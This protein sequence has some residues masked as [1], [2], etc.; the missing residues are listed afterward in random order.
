MYK[1]I[2]TKTSSQEQYTSHVMH[3]TM[4]IRFY[5]CQLNYLITVIVGDHYEG[6]GCPNCWGSLVISKAV[7]KWIVGRMAKS[8]GHGELNYNAV[9]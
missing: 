2:Y 9:R 6:Q 3:M 4:V 1:Y 7:T 8:E 5:T